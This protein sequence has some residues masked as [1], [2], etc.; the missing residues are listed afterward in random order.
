[1][2]NNFEAPVWLLKMV[3]ECSIVWCDL[4]M[5]RSIVHCQ[6]NHPRK[7]KF[8]RNRAILPDHFSGVKF[9]NGLFFGSAFFWFCIG[10]F[11]G[12]ALETS[13][14]CHH[15]IKSYQTLHSWTADMNSCKMCPLKQLL[16]PT[17]I[18]VVIR[19][20]NFWPSFALGPGCYGRS[21]LLWIWLCA[22]LPA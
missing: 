15:K 21:S 14:L 6:R 9:Y 17:M 16:A 5:G 13:K 7:P 19:L 8:S 12:N 22:A 11:L 10:L 3:F 4:R 1:M 18:A 2:Q 20:W